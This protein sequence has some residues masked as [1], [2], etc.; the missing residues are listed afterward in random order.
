MPKVAFS[1]WWPVA[2]VDAD[3]AAVGVLHHVGVRV[4]GESQIAERH[5]AGVDELVRLARGRSPETVPRLDGEPGFAVAVDAGARQHQE[6]LVGGVMPVEGRRGLARRHL[7]KSGAQP[8]QAELHADDRRAHLEARAGFLLR[9][10][11]VLKIDDRPHGA[12]GCLAS[13]CVVAGHSEK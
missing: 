13:A 6:H 1:R 4:V 9:E 8:E 11:Q 10:R 5:V 12:H 3:A 2:P 7:V